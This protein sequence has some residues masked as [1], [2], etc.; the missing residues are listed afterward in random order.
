MFTKEKQAAYLTVEADHVPLR[1]YL[2][3]EFVQNTE[4]SACF[5]E[6]ICDETKKEKTELEVTASDL[7]VPF[8]G[9]SSC[10]RGSI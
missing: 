6:E 7:F 3:W 8:R 2:D 4:L 10:L 5:S 1:V 9:V